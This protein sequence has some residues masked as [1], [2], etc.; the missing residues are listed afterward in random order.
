VTECNLF[1]IK[2]IYQKNNHQFTIEW[3]DGKI[4][5]YRLSDLQKQCPC[6]QCTDEST[7]RRLIGDSQ[8]DPDVSAKRVV[9]IGRYALRIDFLKG[10]SAGIYS[11]DM[12]R[13]LA[14]E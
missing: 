2:K 12:L 1:V 10:C 8:I 3:S 9:S 6:A 11:F 5:N 4:C 13:R 14:K 7:G